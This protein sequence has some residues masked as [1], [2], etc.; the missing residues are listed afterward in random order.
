[1]IERKFFYIF[2]TGIYLTKTMNEK[3]FLIFLGDNLADRIRVKF[4]KEK[5][6]II[7]LIIQYEA[8]IREK[9]HT[10]VRYD[11]EHGFFHR[12]RLTPK[13]EKEKKVIEMPD[14]NTA[15]AYARQDIEDRWEWYKEQY[16]K[17][18]E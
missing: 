6:E 17:K 13:G 5:G 1:M 3:E 15:F 7:D 10:I 16:L 8:L 4:S 2:V 18:M 11:C 9:W 12:D 14:L